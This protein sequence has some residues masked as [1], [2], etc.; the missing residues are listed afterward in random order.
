MKEKG[1]ISEVVVSL[2]QSDSKEVYDGKGILDALRVEL[3]IR[4]RPPPLQPEERGELM[5][6]KLGGVR[7]F[8]TEEGVS[9]GS[10]VSDRDRISSLLSE[11]ASWMEAGLSRW[12]VMDEAD[13]MLRC[14]MVMVEDKVGPGLTSISPARR[15]MREKRK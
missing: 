2:T 13:L 9:T 5:I 6:E 1:L 15:S 7:L 10:Q 3:K 14:E 11:I 4:A 12:G 8:S